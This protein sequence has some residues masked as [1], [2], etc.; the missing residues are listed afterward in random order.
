[1]PAL[2]AGLP[3]LEG[4]AEMGFESTLSVVGRGFAIDLGARHL[5]ESRPVGA[6]GDG[7]DGAIEAGAAGVHFEDQLASEKKCGHLGGKVLIPTLIARGMKVKVGDAVVLVVTNA[8]GSVNGRTFTVGGILDGVTGPGGRD[9]YI[10]IDDAREL[11]RMDKP[12][13]MEIVK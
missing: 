11:L 10:H 6:R 7:C 3:Q 2:L 5:A 8:S 12:E 1:M 4:L 9:G 13:V